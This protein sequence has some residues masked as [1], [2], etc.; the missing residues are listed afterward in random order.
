[1]FSSTV[2]CPEGLILIRGYSTC[3]TVCIVRRM[4]SRIQHGRFG[5]RPFV[6]VTL[7]F[8]FLVV[9]VARPALC[10]YHLKPMFRGKYVI[11][12]GACYGRL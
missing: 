1:M 4:F 11:S 3:T 12:E 8:C 9:I 10:I 2:S 5:V 6:F 7:G